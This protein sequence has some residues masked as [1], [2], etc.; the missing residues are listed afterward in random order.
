MRS[1]VTWPCERQVHWRKI[2][3]SA[4]L[5]VWQ[6]STAGHE[7]ARISASRE[8]SISTRPRR[9]A[10]GLDRKTLLRVLIAAIGLTVLS[11]FASPCYV[12]VLPFRTVS[13]AV[14]AECT[15]G[16]P[17]GQVSQAVDPQYAAFDDPRNRAVPIT[18]PSTAVPVQVDPFAFVGNLAVFFALCVITA[19]AVVPSRSMRA[20]QIAV[21][22]LVGLVATSSFLWLVQ[23]HPEVVNGVRPDRVETLAGWP[24]G[25]ARLAPQESADFSYRNV[26]G[27]LAIPFAFS[28]AATVIPLMAVWSTVRPSYGRSQG[29]DRPK[30]RS[31]R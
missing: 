14:P 1:D 4:H 10:R 27:V 22:L 20:P 23:R 13:D 6:R 7:G 9:R 28:L 19:L 3:K 24:W 5:L 26:A 11:T 31:N 29:R 15:W 17:F 16:W 30:Q 12:I 2:A 21:I 8:A 18:G 25:W